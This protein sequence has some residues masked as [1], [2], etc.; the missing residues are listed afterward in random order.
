MVNVVMSS[1]T[2]A[3]FGSPL[4][5][6][7]F[8]PESIALI[9]QSDNPKRPSG[10]PLRYLRRDG[11]EGKVYPINPRRDTV[12]AEPAYKDLA[13]LPQRPDHAYILL[14]TDLAMTSFT[15]CCDAGIPVVQMLAD[16]FAES[17]HEGQERQDKLVRQAQDAGIRLLGPNCMGVADL[18]SGLSL[19]VNAVFDEDIQRGGRTALIS[20]SGS[21][22][23]GL[24]SRA[25]SLGV[26]FS[27][28]AAVGNEADLG[29]GEIGQMLVGDPETDVILL[30]LETIRQPDEIAKF[31]ATAHAAGKPIIAFKLGRSSVGQQLAVAH[32]GA[33]LSEDSLVDAFFRDLGIIRV[34]VLEALFEAATL[35]R[36]RKPIG[37]P[38]PKVGVLT[39][40]GGGGAAACDQLSFV[41]VDLLTPNDDTIAKIRATGIDVGQGPMTDV[42]LAGARADIIGPS[43]SAMAADPDC[44]I[45][46]AVL[47]SSSRAAPETA[48]PP[49]IEA[50]VGD[51]TLAAF[52]V[53]DAVT[54]LR[55]LTDSGI[56]GFRTPESCADAIRAYCRWQEP[57]IQAIAP[58]AQETAGNALNE[59][60]SLELFQ[61]MGIPTVPSLAIKLTE[62]AQAELPFD[63]PVVAK[64]LSDRIAH[65][66]DA[67]GVVVNIAD[68]DDLASA[69][70]Q[71]KRSVEAANPDVTVDEILVEP[72]IE[73]VQEVLVGYHLDQQVGPVVT[74]AP[75]GI[76]VGVYDDKAV[77]L[78]PVDIATARTMIDEVV[79][80][81]PMR[82]HRGGPKGDEDA[83][84]KIIIAMSNL[85]QRTDIS[86]I[87]A[88]A[89]PVIV[90]TES[91]TAVDAFIRIADLG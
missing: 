79:G 80:F 18:N 2:A 52:L 25:A 51:K 12:Q 64:V 10:R 90:A 48:L 58:I 13:S 73:G 41:G 36:G 47:G 33:L 32:T 23:G 65:K 61:Q 39:T 77:R 43:V 40:T 27:K 22:M 29:V 76:H 60:D 11:F 20:Q 54:G 78:A 15:A 62:I 49:V 3:R 63:F 85:G 30:F 53:P 5:Q 42:T 34:T 17:G 9:G 19:T 31:A 14:D 28:I 16:G 24:M 81:A 69:A 71:I 35:C 74:V 82:G 89:N 7:L 26:K 75:G 56:P 6:A 67:G 72:M 68:R 8:A 88:E 50:D 57:R 55:L 86:V 91:A 4:W 66:T 21:M 70:E 37:K 84:A 38:R 1:D 87:E 44:D 45:V 59:H 83:L 46:L